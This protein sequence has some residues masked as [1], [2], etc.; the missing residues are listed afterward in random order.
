MKLKQILEASEWR[1]A[2][3][4]REA[5][6][7]FL[8]VIRSLVDGSI[9]RRVVDDDLS[10]VVFDFTDEVPL[11]QFFVILF[12]NPR[13]NIGG[14]MGKISSKQFGGT[15]HPDRLGISINLENFFPIYD[16]KNEGPRIAQELNKRKTIF[17]HEFVHLVDS[18]RMGE[19]FFKNKATISGDGRS[20]TYSEYFNN[21]KELNTYYQQTASVLDDKIRNLERYEREIP[22]IMQRKFGTTF[23]SAFAVFLKELPRS[24]WGHLSPENKKK[25]RKRFYN[26]WVDN[27]KPYV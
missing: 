5:E 3:I 14:Q 2:T 13:T 6:R 17:I 24:F 25:I 10:Y 26:Y 19:V 15:A 23:E 8:A 20:A 4:R 21:P 18:R 27:I 7:V 9:V 11:R 12:S 22:D 1:D 16:V